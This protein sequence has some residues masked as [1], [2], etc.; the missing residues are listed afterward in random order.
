MS[1]YKILIVDENTDQVEQFETFFDIVSK[2]GISESNSFEI[3]NLTELED[4]NDL[5]RCI[6]D[7][8]IDC[9]AFDYKLMENNS[10]FSQQGD[11]YQ[12]HLLEHFEGFPT[13]I[14]TNNSDDYKKMNSDPF[15]I[16][17]KKVINFDTESP[18]EIAEAKGLIDKIIHL[19]DLYKENLQN[20]EKEFYD[21]I[22]KQKNEEKLS[23][24]DFARLVEL[25]SKIE[26]SISRKSIIPKDWKSP[27][28]I[29]AITNLA[30]NSQIILQELKKLNNE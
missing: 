16:I 9:V 2:L 7:N 30:D 28:G 21:L 12:S 27:G 3:F 4:E 5:Y 14:I 17:S 13:F 11:I 29:E 20:I 25:D 6:T 10:S 23:D 26:N 8:D 1:N 19:V 24:I 15:K 22:E 18:E